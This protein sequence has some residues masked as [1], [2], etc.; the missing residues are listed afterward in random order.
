M[1]QTSFALKSIF[2]GPRTFLSAA[3][4]YLKTLE[5]L[6]QAEQPTAKH[7]FAGARTFLSAATFLYRTFKTHSHRSTVQPCCGQECPRSTIKPA[8]SPS[9]APHPTCS[10]PCHHRGHC[11]AC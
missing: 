1:F 6:R 9:P 2:P 11:Q 10:R 3:T 4:R 7:L 8:S 5:F